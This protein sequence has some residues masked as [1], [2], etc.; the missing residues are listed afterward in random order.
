MMTELL[1]LPKRIY[2][3]KTELI[4]DLKKSG[5]TGSSINIDGET[6][7][8]IPGTNPLKLS[9]VAA[10]HVIPLAILSLTES[11]EELDRATANLVLMSQLRGQFDFN[12][13]YFNGLMLPHVNAEGKALTAS[14]SDLA[15]H[16]G[17]HG[18]YLMAIIKNIQKELDKPENSELLELLTDP[19][20]D[21]II[22]GV[23]DALVQASGPSYLT[24]GLSL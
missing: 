10:H 20:F 19:D 2:A 12:N 4:S 21:K 5:F 18:P 3:S 15:L 16:G 17:P 7:T 22:T 9:G 1:S 13:T 6:L 23:P 11:S 8:E 24:A 14:Q